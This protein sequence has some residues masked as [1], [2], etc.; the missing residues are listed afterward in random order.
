MKIVVVSGGFDPIHSGHIAYLKEAKKLGDKLIVAL[1]SDDWLIKK[2]GKFFMPFAERE[3]I[4]KN[5]KPV[6]D[7]ISFEDDELGSCKDALNKTKLKYPD[8]EILFCN[9]GDRNKEN[10][11]EMEVS[12]VT[13][14]FE[15]GGED[16]KNS[17]SWILK[18]F[19]HSSENRVWGKFYNLFVDENLK[20]KELIVDP[21][22][23]MSF[24]RHFH[25]NEIWFVSKGKCLVNFSKVDAEN[26][27]SIELNKEQVFHVEKEAWHQITNP[28]DK[29]CH[30]IEI[31]YG[32]KT[33]ED[34]IERLRFYDNEN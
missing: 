21:K 5:L 31:Q 17:S 15:V 26:F 6:D 14:H 4:L 34:D 32:E 27:Q 24:Q 22:K 25:R 18:N 33:D 3:I 13:F 20:L 28:F 16:K 8:E 7:V 23:G 11:P 1:N 2:K 19:E 30:I 29:P 12:D 10:I 9:G